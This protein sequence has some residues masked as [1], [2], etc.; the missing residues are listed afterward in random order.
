VTPAPGGPSLAVVHLVRFEEGRIV[1]LW[2]VVSPVPEKPLN[3]NG[4]F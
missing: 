1:E 4:V 2:D 3:A